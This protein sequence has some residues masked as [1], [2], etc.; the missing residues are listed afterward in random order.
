MGGMDAPAIS[1][2]RADATAE[3][4]ARVRAAAES[5]ARARPESTNAD[6]AASQLRTLSFPSVP[7]S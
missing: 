2:P 6:I 4:A 3:A 1:E 7:H 5:A